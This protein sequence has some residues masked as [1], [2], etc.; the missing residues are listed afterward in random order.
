MIP[1]PLLARL[2]VLAGD[3]SCRYWRCVAVVS[4]QEHEA[5]AR[6]DYEHNPSATAARRLEEAPGKYAV[7][8]HGPQAPDWRGQLPGSRPI[9]AAAAFTPE[10]IETIADHTIR[11]FFIG[12]I[13]GTRV[14]RDP[15]VSASQGRSELADRRPAHRLARRRRRAHVAQGRDGESR[16]PQGRLSRLSVEHPR[17]V[18]L[19]SALRRGECR[20]VPLVLTASGRREHDQVRKSGSS[21]LPERSRSNSSASGSTVRRT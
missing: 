13:L 12:V 5:K 14:P 6:A 17:L 20:T 4:P 1:D 9:E 19:Q 16:H 21:P 2:Q 18:V 8:F 15:G 7:I 3:F 11:K 10:G